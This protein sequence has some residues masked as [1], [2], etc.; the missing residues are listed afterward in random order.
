MDDRRRVMIID[1]DDGIREML[2]SA[3]TFAG[4]QVSCATDGPTALEMLTTRGTDAIVLDVMMPGVDGFEVVQLLRHRGDSVPVLFLSARDTVQDRVKGLQLGGD[5]YLTKPFSIVEVVARLESLLRRS[6]VHPPT[7][8]DPDPSEPPTLRCGNLELDKLI[9]A[10]SRLA[11]SLQAL[12]GVTLG[13]EQLVAVLARQATITVVESAG[14]AVAWA[15][16]DPATASDLVRSTVSE[17]EPDSVDGH[18]DLV[19]IRV[20]T[21]GMGLATRT[22]EGLVEID[23]VVIALDSTDDLA[24]VRG[25]IATNVIATVV[26]IV[27]LIV[28]S[29]VIIGRGLRPLRAISQRAAAVAAGGRTTRLT[30]PDNDPDIGLLAE[31]VNSAFDAQ[32]AAEVRLRNFVAD[33]SHELRTP[34]T[35]ASGWVEL[36]LQGGLADLPKRDQAMERVEAELGRMRLLVDE[37]ALLARIDQGRPLDMAVLDVAS[38]AMDV[39]EDARVADPQSRVT[40]EAAGPAWVVGDAARMQQVLR[41]LI[42]NAVQHTPTGTAVHVSIFQERSGDPARALQVLQV[43]DKGPGI[44]FDDRQH[45][46]ERFWRGDHSRSRNTGGSGLGLAIVQSIVQAHGGTIEISSQQ[47]SGTCVRVSVPIHD[48]LGDQA[49][50][51]TG[52]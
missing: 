5:D 30:V 35:T 28:L 42:G 24:S 38:L 37:L 36:Y 40:F 6:Q 47:P 44:P 49:G 4:F 2:Q 16:T 23:G 25:I 26:A 46:F 50:K 3:L 11:P 48:P 9:A 52:G 1:D 29:N 8:S 22:S 17:V 10:A 34:L 13:Y 20:D 7:I 51:P 15:R 14:Q 39:V 27:A 19:A 18:P 32:Q 41:N 31:T 12:N 43:S 21:E 45:A 33:A